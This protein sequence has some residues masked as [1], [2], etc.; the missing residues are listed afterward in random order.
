MVDEIVY[1]RIGAAIRVHRPETY[2]QASGWAR[3]PCGD[4]GRVRVV[5]KGARPLC[6]VCFPPPIRSGRGK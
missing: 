3:T 1:V 5:A 6:P 2:N 4:E